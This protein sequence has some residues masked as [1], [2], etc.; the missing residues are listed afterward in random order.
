MIAW[1]ISKTHMSLILASVLIEKLT[2]DVS[3]AERQTTMK[4]LSLRQCELM[5]SYKERKAIS[6]AAHYAYMGAHSL[7]EGARKRGGYA[8]VT[9]DRK[10]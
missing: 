1:L 5:L 4:P 8:G 9:D 3:A 6:D 7:A 2:D 10:A